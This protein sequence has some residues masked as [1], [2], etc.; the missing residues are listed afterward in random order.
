MQPDDVSVHLDLGEP[1]VE[2][3]EYAK[4]NI[5]EIPDT[6]PAAVQ[7]LRDLIYER[8]DVEVHRSDDSFLLRFLRARQFHGERA[9]RLL[10]NYYKFKENNPEIHKGIDPM[11]LNFIGEDDVL[12]VLPYR[13]QT[14]RRIMIYRVGNWDPSRYGVDEIM[15]ATVVIL[16]LAVLEQRAQILGGVCI[17]DLGGLSL[18]HAWHV[19]PTLAAKVVNLLGLSF[20]IRI[21]AIHVIN[22][23]WVFDMVFAIF[24]PL[25]DQRMRDKIYVHGDNLESLHSHIDPK[26]LPEKYGGTRPEY[27]YKDWMDSLSANPDIIKEMSSLGYIISDDDDDKVPSF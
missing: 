11:K 22:Q 24:K 6:R 18:S 9:Y 3:L 1:P 27:S 21:H 2:L 26:F 19:T 13:E 12:G 25:L 4:E 15:K 5:G 20:P 8:G 17:F 10:V 14:G 7:D 16:E 23:S